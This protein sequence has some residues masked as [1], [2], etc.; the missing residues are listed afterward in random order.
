MILLCRIFFNAYEIFFEVR[1]A[2]LVYPMLDLSF[3]AFPLKG[4]PL[5][6]KKWSSVSE[7]FMKIHGSFQN[8]AVPFLL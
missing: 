5:K 2:A 1:E 7:E 4:P 3:D 8:Q 6:A